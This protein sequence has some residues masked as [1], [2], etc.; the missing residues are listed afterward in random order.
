MSRV[1]QIIA[2]GFK[3]VSRKYRTLARVPAGKAP[4]DALR[5]VNPQAA[6]RL[7]ERI[8]DWATDEYIRCHAEGENK[9]ELSVEEFKEY[10][11]K[12]GR[13]PVLKDETP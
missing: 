13:A 1:D 9:V 10:L 11:G 6:K 4:L 12:T 3:Q 5:E 7:E 2:G 8:A